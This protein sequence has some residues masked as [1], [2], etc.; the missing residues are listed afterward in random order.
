MSTKF[1]VMEATIALVNE[2]GKLNLLRN[3]LKKVTLEDQLVIDP[4]DPFGSPFASETQVSLRQ[5]IRSIE[6]H[7]KKVLKYLSSACGRALQNYNEQNLLERRFVSKHESKLVPC[8]AY[9]VIN[10]GP[11]LH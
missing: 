3:R 8:D 11:G 4:L 1:T 2:F 10:C 5:E 6:R 7:L 9:Q